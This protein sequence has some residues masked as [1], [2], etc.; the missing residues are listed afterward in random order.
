LHS[1]TRIRLPSSRACGPRAAR[2]HQR[3]RRDLLSAHL[4][5]RDP[6][7]HYDSAQIRR[8]NS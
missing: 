8:Q 3:R 4:A 6:G 7:S 2:A 1:R 5:D